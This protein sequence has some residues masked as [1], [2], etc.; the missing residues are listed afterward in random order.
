M[1]PKKLKFH[2]INYPSFFINSE[3]SEKPLENL[4]FFYKEA[5]SNL[6]KD[7]IQT[8]QMIDQ[9]PFHYR[10][11][12][13]QYEKAIGPD[14]CNKINKIGVDIDRN[15]KN[16]KKWINKDIEDK[17]VN[18]RT[19]SYPLRN[20]SMNSNGSNESN[21]SNGSLDTNMCSNFNENSAENKN[22]NSNFTCNNINKKPTRKHTKKNLINSFHTI[23]SN[24]ND[25]ISE[26]QTPI[27][28]KIFNSTKVPKIKTCFTKCS[29]DISSTG[30]S[31][32]VNDPA[33][34][35]LITNGI[36]RKIN[37]IFE[38]DNEEDTNGLFA[39]ECSYNNFSKK[40][41]NKDLKF[42]NL[43]NYNY[44]FDSNNSK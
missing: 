15:L 8:N 40:D 14:I 17:E 25:K 41:S 24:D 19:I 34:R 12:I 33:S 31:R 21:G 27:T 10:M 6:N 38:N 26:P 13:E 22:S 23:N 1:N 29:P 4:K 3:N 32:N 5:E 43:E 37:L 16:K 9:E 2:C 28:G 18:N 11:E 35:S 44:C 20:F 7:N 30:R 36:P 42:L 39:K